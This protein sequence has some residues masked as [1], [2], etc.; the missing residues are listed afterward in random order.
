MGKSLIPAHDNRRSYQ[1][2]G[3]T[4]PAISLQKSCSPL[5]NRSYR[6]RA[7]GR[8]TSTILQKKP[9]IRKNL[10]IYGI[11]PV[12]IR[13]RAPCKIHRSKKLILRDLN[14]ALKHEEKEGDIGL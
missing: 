4:C 14:P 9:L 10:A 5:R 12:D 2:T 3:S 8:D 1:R 11:F 6:T 7:K 13:I